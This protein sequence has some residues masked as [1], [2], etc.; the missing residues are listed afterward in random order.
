M[1]TQLKKELRSL[2]A[3]YTHSIIEQILDKGIKNF[4]LPDFKKIKKLVKQPLIVDG[5]NIYDPRKMKNLGFKYVGIG[6]R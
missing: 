5:R 4:T 1:I 2:N 6:R 3:Y